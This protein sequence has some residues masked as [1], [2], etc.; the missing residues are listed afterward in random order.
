MVLEA[1][2]TTSGDGGTAKRG[3][4]GERVARGKHAIEHVM[5][6][7]WVSHWPLGGGATEGERD[8]LIHTLGNLTLITGRLNST[9]SN[10]AWDG[11]EGKQAT[12]TKHDTLFLNRDIWKSVTS[13]T[14][15]TIR[16]RTREL[17]DHIS[18]IWPVPPGHKSPA[19][20]RAKVSAPR[21]HTVDLAD[22]LNAGL[23]TAGMTLHPRRR[24]IADRV[25]TLLP[26]GQL[27][28]AGV[29]YPT[30]FA[31]A[32]A[33]TGLRMNGWW[34]FLVEQKPKRSLKDVRRE[35]LDKLDVDTD[36]DDSDDEG[37]DADE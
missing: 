21:R 2:R 19:G 9:L 4:A 37:D 13:W 23:L 18:A 32:S 30:P 25:A 10:A 11:S 35:Y 16:A 28:V 26:D 3:S 29:I 22:L 17:I 14:E 15:D 1:L 24:K 8:Q 7:K 5:P 31:A 34:L 12:L 33:L 36:D 6:R 27:D 20:T